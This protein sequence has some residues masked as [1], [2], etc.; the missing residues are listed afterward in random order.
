MKKIL[1]MTFAALFVVSISAQEVMSRGFGGGG[2]RGAGGGSGGYR[3]GGAAYRSPS[4]SRPS[5]ARVSSYQPSRQV[6]RQAPPRQQFTPRPAT[7]T[8]P[9]QGAVGKLDRTATTRPTQGQLQQ[10]LNLP[11]NQRPGRASDL[12]KIG[13][14]A[15]A[16][17]LGVEGARKLLEGQK[18]GGLER[19]SQLP[20][21][22]GLADRR[23]EA[24][25]PST[26]P[27]R[28]VSNQIRDN[29]QSRHDKPFAPQWWKDHPNAARHYWDQ[30]HH[31]P[32]NYWWRAAT[33]GALAGWTAGAVAGSGYG[34]PIYYDYG[35]NI[36]YEGDDV[37]VGGTK[38]ATAEEYYQQASTLAENAPEATDQGAEDWLPLGV[39]ALSKSNVADSNMVLQLA[40]NKEGVISGMYYNTNTDAGRP[41][42][43]MVDKQSQRAAWTFADGK[44]T[45]IIME[46]GLYNLTQDQTEALVHFGKDKTQQWLMVRL[47]QP[48][49]ETQAEK[50][51]S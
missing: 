35:Q 23:G 13:A 19:P 1:L 29:W 8:M 42:K 22:A 41:I 3:S 16:G 33:W 27:E 49:E 25:R 39:F 21:R 5:S 34:D 14:G 20:E 46:T 10:F 44:N 38:T 9:G 31:H 32:W 18:P 50:K 47:K 7:G 37:Y 15:V 36:Y 24:G 40:I 17:A 30:H 26:L 6:S 28:N 48:E 11:Q 2:G 45:D 12:S 51:D 4:M 43:G